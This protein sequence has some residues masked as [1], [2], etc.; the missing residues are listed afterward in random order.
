M[1]GDGNKYYNICPR[2]SEE[3]VVGVGDDVL[4]P[5]LGKEGEEGWKLRVCYDLIPAPFRP[6]T[7]LRPP[8][9]T[10]GY[11]TETQPLEVRFPAFF[12]PP[13]LTSLI[14]QLHC[15]VLSASHIRPSRECGYPYSYSDALPLRAATFIHEA[16]YGPVLWQS[17]MRREPLLCLPFQFYEMPHHGAVGCQSSH[18][19][20]IISPSP[21]MRRRMKTYFG[22]QGLGYTLMEQ[23]QYDEQRIDDSTCSD[24]CRIPR[25]PQ[26]T[27]G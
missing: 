10:A 25:Q 13:Y 21:W 5:V 8:V 7:I 17:H 26:P 1:L 18:H 22:V 2:W 19:Y 27:L 3:Q 15:T 12:P 24:R 4:R 11:V 14:S 23:G 16:L 6:L 20:C 9:L